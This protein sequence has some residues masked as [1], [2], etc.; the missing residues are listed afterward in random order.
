MKL[1]LVDNEPKFYEFIRLLR[2][3]TDNISGF[4]NQNFISES[5][6][7]TYMNKFHQYFKIC[8]LDGEPAGFIG[9]IEDDIRVATKPEFKKKGIAKFMVNEIMKIYPE[10][11]AK[12]KVDNLSSIKLFESC[13][14]KTEFIIMKKCQ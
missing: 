12:V 3:H 1:E 2:L 5:E 4:I 8:L 10:A 9:V 14:F 6:Q 13:G 11:L 7:K